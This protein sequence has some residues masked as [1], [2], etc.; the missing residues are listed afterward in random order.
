MNFFILNLIFPCIST[1]P[2]KISVVY[3]HS[4]QYHRTSWFY[5]DLRNFPI[6]ILQS[7]DVLIHVIH[8]AFLCDSQ[9]LQSLHSYE[10][11]IQYIKSIFGISCSSK[12]YNPFIFVSNFT[13]LTFH[14]LCFSLS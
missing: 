8:P 2:F 10:L 6:T 1:Y 3:E 13:K 7:H 11:L 9:H 14:V 5:N 4:I 12:S